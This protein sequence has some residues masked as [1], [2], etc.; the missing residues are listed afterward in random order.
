MDALLSFT[1]LIILVPLTLFVVLKGKHLHKNE[2][3]Y[4]WG[5]GILM[6]IATIVAILA[7]L[8]IGLT[9]ET[10]EGIP[11]IYQ[12]VFQGHMT[13]AFFILVMFAGAFK[14][15]S[16]PKI[17]LMRVRRENAI[18]GFMFLVPH[19]AF[20]VVIALGALNPTGT[21]AFLIM[22][23]LFI[24]SFPKIRKKMHPLQWRKLHKWAYPAYAMIYIHVASINTI[25]QEDS[26]RFVRLAIYTIIFAVYTYLKFKNYILAPKKKPAAQKKP[27]N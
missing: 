17:M 23:P 2:Y 13:F 16:K 12:T 18:L 26:L 27:S 20:L 22:L 6:C 10:I 9:R 5:V 19:A 4:Y 21:I 3:K 24:T 14:Q 15:K 1:T 11:F 25:A 8:G 7:Q